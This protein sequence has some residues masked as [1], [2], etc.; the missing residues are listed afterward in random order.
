MICTIIH[1][2]L[3]YFGYKSL[4]CL[5]KIFTFL[6]VIEEFAAEIHQA[7]IS[8]FALLAE[9]QLKATTADCFSLDESHPSKY[10]SEGSKTKHL[11]R[12]TIRNRNF[13]TF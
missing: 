12:N 2:A 5:Q 8:H 11:K 4:H 13:L 3:G 1:L 6:F 9:F 10:Y 7:Q